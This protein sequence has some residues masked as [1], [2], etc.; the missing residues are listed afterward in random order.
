MAAANGSGPELPRDFP[1][2]WE[3]WEQNRT[4]PI[5]GKPA[6]LRPIAAGLTR[7]LRP[8]AR[9][10]LREQRAFNLFLIEAIERVRSDV[11]GLD[12]ARAELHDDLLQVRGDLLGDVQ[13]LGLVLD[14]LVLFNRDAFDDVM[15]HTDALFARVD[16][17]F[18]RYR[19]E[20]HELM[21]KLGALLVAA[22]GG[23]TALVRASEEMDY[24]GLE[25]RF[26]G[27]EATIGERLRPYLAYLRGAGKVLDLGCG[28]GEAVAILRQEG[29]DASGVDSSAEMVRRCREQGLPVEEGDLFTA[30]E[31]QSEGSLHGVVSF[32]VIE[33]LEAA[34]LRRLVRLVWRALAPSGVLI[35]ETPN[36]LSLVVAARN[37]WLDPTHRRPVHPAT[38]QLLYEQ[39]GFEQIERLDLRPFPPA[40]RLPEVDPAALP[41]EL[42][43]LGY[44][45]NELR[46]RLDELLFGCQDYALIG[47][48]AGR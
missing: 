28:R 8:L 47:R 30:L 37:F 34:S 38:L 16:Q 44:R 7:L 12:R 36:P 17:K 20:A 35:L 40:E 1:S 19:R 39:A 42:A 18:D 3:L 25:E 21:A 14:H 5:R 46:D 29:I 31:G 2:W 43:T 33:H 10:V 6:W 13:A 32:H 48:K 4:L 26:R 11:A 45:V 24:L 15:H 41:S 23:P 9:R 22:Q 27:V